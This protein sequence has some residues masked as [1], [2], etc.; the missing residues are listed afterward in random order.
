MLFSRKPTN[1]R[2]AASKKKFRRLLVEQME[3]RCMFVVGAFSIPAPV[4]PGA[5]FD[6]VVQLNSD[7]GSCTGSL[8]GGG[9]HILTAAHCVTDGSGNI[10]VSDLDVTFEMPTSDIVFN[11]SSAMGV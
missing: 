3:Q 5:G 1:T 6:G 10:N 9:Q 4:N 11:V 8:L 2:R 7:L